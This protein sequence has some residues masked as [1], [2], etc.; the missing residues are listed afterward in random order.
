MPII[1][2]DLAG[3]DPALRFSS[4]CWSIKFALAHKGLETE[5]VPWRFQEA[6]NLPQP[7]EG[8]VPV[9]RDGAEVVHDSWTIAEYLEDRYPDRPSLFGG[10]TGRA[11]ARFINEWTETVVLPNVTPMIVLDI[12]QS[13]DADVQPYFRKTREAR[14]GMTL[15]AATQ[16]RQ[17]RLP[18]FH[19]LLVPLRQT[20]SRQ[21]WLG[22]KDPSY[23][24][25]VVAGAFMWPSC[26]SRLAVMPP[27]GPIAG[28][29]GRM[30][31]LYGGLAGKAVRV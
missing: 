26:T 3:R 24:D 6:A 29:W 2:Y 23:A 31:D 19:A 22:G 13:L 25:H 7:N 28:W 8:R 5:T 17:L 20:L 18:A 27:D 30:Q 14:L 10:A 12:F 21:P 4:R 1:L 15:E 16:D 9:I 11:H